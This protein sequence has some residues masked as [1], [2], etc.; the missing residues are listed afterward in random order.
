VIVKSADPTSA[1]TVMRIDVVGG[2]AGLDQAFFAFRPVAV[3]EPGTWLLFTL[4]V[5]LLAWG[6]RQVNRQ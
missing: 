4:V 2:S 1:D 3:P 5:P 6:R